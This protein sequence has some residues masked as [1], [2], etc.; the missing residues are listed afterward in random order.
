[1]DL[2]EIFGISAEPVESEIR[3]TGVDDKFEQALGA[4]NHIVVFGASKQGKTRLVNRVIPQE[5]QLRILC[6]PHFSREDIYR[7]L[8]AEAKVELVEQ[9][10]VQCGSENTK[11]AKGKVSARF[12]AIG[13]DVEGASGTAKRTQ[14]ETR[15]REVGFNLSSP[16][17]VNRILIDSGKHDKRII[18]D[19][20][21]YL[22]EE[23]QRQFAFDLRLWN[24]LNRSIIILGVWKQASFVQTFNTDLSGRITDIPVEPWEPH[25]FMDVLET[26][27]RKLGC[28]LDERTARHL[29]TAANGSIGLFQDMVHGAFYRAGVMKSG[30]GPS[31]LNLSDQIPD[32][33]A[34]TADKLGE[35]YGKAIIRLSKDDTPGRVNP[36]YLKFYLAKYL[37]SVKPS[38]IFAG[39]RKNDFLEF[40]AKDFHRDIQGQESRNRLNAS[41]SQMLH[42]LGPIQAGLG[43]PTLLIYSKGQIRLVDPLCLFFL[44]NADLEI[45]R[46]D[47]IAPWHA[48]DAAD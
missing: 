47:I 2:R 28:T 23:V 3:R 19:N 14:E 8:L 45:V 36:L 17:D 7:T 46:E 34:A 35:A 13:S 41:V 15:F 18:L 40:C 24:D 26:G 38:A 30:E 5:Q 20:F 16:Q 1:M 6:H 22:T 4:T 31:T 29:V 27:Q 32:I 21:H 44:E 9:K 42:K 12:M 25:H 11:T 39:V 33:L 10:V 48:E 43:I 37:L